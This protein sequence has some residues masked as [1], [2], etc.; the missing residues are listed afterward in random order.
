MLLHMLGVL[1]KC[2]SLFLIPFTEIKVFDYALIP[3]SE[4]SSLMML[5]VSEF[6]FHFAM[7]A[8]AIVIEQQEIAPFCLKTIEHIFLMFH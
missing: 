7:E 3:E 6:T 1:Y 4:N 8:T 5:P 2:L